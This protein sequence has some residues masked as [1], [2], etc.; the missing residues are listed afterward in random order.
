MQRS[1]VAETLGTGLLMAVVVGS[2]A[3]SARLGAEPELGLL[4]TSLCCGV[5]LWVLISI[6]APVSGALLN[7]AVTL[8]FA[9]RGEIGGRAALAFGGAQVVGACL[10]T[11]LAHV[12]F[13]L[14]PVQFSILVR[15]QPAL[16]LS[17][18]VATFGLIFVI[19]G[20]LT[21]R[22]PVA[23]LVGAYVSTGYWFT[24]STGFANPAMTVARTLT[25][26]AGGLR[27]ID[28]PAYIAAQ[29]AGAAL[30]IVLGRW[31]FGTTPVG[32][33]AAGHAPRPQ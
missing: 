19:L 21:A 30:A 3:M 4:V 7:P 11:M 16:W 8:T 6:M 13:G 23:G 10:G 24:A 17:E 9:L 14:A 20:A 28:A 31:L 22:G 1:L 2:S 29:F 27:P 5:A 18:G 12:M 25:G 15:D 33:A 26:M 32:L